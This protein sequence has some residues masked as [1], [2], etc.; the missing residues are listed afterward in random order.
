MKEK[1]GVGYIT[2]NS[3]ERVRESLKTIPNVDCLVVVNDGLEDSLPDECIPKGVNVIQHDEN[4][5]VGV[6]K[7]DA[8]K[9]LIENDCDH[10]FLMEDDIIISDENVFEEYIHTAE[11]TG[12]WHFNY[13]L[14]GPENRKKI[15]S[16]KIKTYDDLFEYYYLLEPNPKKIIQ[17]KKKTISLYHHI[18]GC[19]SYYHR[20]VIKHCGFFDDFYFNAFEHIDHTY[21]II[22]KGL[23]PPF[24]WF[25]DIFKS[26][27]YLTS[28]ENCFRSSPRRNDINFE[29]NIKNASEYFSEKYKIKNV[30]DIPIASLDD[31]LDDLKRI[32]KFYSKGENI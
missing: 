18:C 2:C 25:A 21:K 28:V 22:K 29:K 31:V 4:F 24:W 32:H 8:L 27:D 7:N 16:E 30:V 17:Y 12:I 1:I 13:A 26:S 11:E 6:S 15:K 14:Q 23:H 5:G 19:F 10:L 3:E 20:G 9:Y